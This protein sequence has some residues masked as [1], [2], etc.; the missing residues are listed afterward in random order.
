MRPKIIKLLVLLFFIV[1]ITM[2]A[3]PGYSWEKG[4]YKIVPGVK[5]EQKWDSNIFYD[6]NNEKSDWISIISPSIYGE[7]GFGD[8]D[9]HTAKVN[10]VVDLGMFAEFNNQNYG[11]HNVF[12]EVDFDLNDYGFK[13]SDNFLFTSSRAGTDQDNRNLRKENTVSGIWSADFNKLS[14]DVGYSNYILEYLSDTL[15]GLNRMDNTMWTTGYIQ[16]QPKTKML[17]EYK[18]RNIQYPAKVSSG[19][20]GNANSGMIGLKGELTSK[21][22][23]IVKAGYMYQDY[24]NGQDFSAPIAFV[25]LDYRATDRL[26]TLFSYERTAYESSYQGSNYYTGDHM[27]LDVK[28]DLGRNFIAKALG[29]Y[30]R[31]DYD[32]RAPG[33][34]EKRNDNIFGAGCG[35]DYNW[36]EWA[37]CGIGY[38]YK[39]RVSTINDRQYDQHVFSA[40]IKMAF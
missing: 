8:Y 28:Y 2:Q 40:N 23:G 39:Q 24:K 10:Y 14:F 27:L 7:A 37:S 38:N 18:Y 1:G 15:K 30:S 12:G 22:T 32:K 26:S 16:I 36:K 35:L 31:N 11:N 6:S 4:S 20:S 19:R 21:I 25:S 34:A 3:T 17:V 9:K 5:Y 13:V 33:Q 29:E